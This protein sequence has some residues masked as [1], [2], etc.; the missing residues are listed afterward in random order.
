MPLQ[1]NFVQSNYFEVNVLNTG[2]IGV[3]LYHLCNM[4]DENEWCPALE[5]YP[6]TC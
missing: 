5:N 2:N 6:Y 3:I 1:V 4:E